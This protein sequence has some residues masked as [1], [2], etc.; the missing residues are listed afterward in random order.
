MEVH[1]TLT[2]QQ[3]TYVL[4][5]PVGSVSEQISNSTTLNVE[6]VVS[7]VINEPDGKSG[8]NSTNGV[9]AAPPVYNPG[10]PWTQNRSLVQMEPVNWQNGPYE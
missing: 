3:T 4:P 10:D 2:S 9:T 8:T 7:G 6:P 1:E 5:P